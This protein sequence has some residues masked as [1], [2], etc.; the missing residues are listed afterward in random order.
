MQMPLPSPVVQALSILKMAGFEA[1]VVGGCVRDTMLGKQ[2]MDW[3]ITTS[4][5]PEQ[6]L[7]AFA[8]YKTV[9]TGIQHGTVT[10]IVENTPLEVTTY[11]ID[12]EYA[13]SRHPNEVFF[14]SSLQE[15][16][17]RRDFTINA[18][19]YHPEKGLVDCFSGA[20]DLA[21]QKI[22]CVGDPACRFTEDALRIL[23]ALR[24]SAVLGFSIEKV[25][26]DTI[27]K[28]APLLRRVSAE[29]IADE[30]KK[31]LVGE[32]VRQVL[33]D[34][35]DVFCVILPELQPLIGLR[36]DNPYH[37]LTVYEHTVETV[38]AIKNDL[39]LRLTM[40]FHDVGKPA[41]Y[42]RDASGIDHFRGHPAISTAIAE[43]AMERLRLDNATISAVKVLIMHHD[44]S[45]SL[46]D[47]QLKRLLNRL[48]S[49]AYQLVEVQRADVY[50]QHPDKRDRL[51]FLDAVENR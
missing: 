11:R 20:A 37:H 29:R 5:L 24:F 46:L 48:E 7:S 50:G 17:R 8:E 6:I 43:R 15:D 16:L 14:T 42:T 22:T 45:L 34:F 51:S 31:L 40:L 2:P 4:A 13:D 44:D 36:Q 49:A 27:H 38:A 33:L 25:T 9:P 30:L 3:D 10:V 35:A 41:C 32:H 18:M 12:G 21:A 23:R 19:A 26:A 28:L 1:Y 47:K 39:P